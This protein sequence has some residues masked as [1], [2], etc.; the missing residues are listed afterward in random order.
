MWRDGR[1]WW[2]A[3]FTP[4]F[5]A[6]VNAAGDVDIADGDTKLGPAEANRLVARLQLRP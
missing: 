2:E 6:H 4:Q 5:A 3:L 1:F